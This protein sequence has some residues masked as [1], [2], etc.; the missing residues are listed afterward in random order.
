[1]SARV[2]APALPGLPAEE[3]LR[4]AVRGAWRGRRRA[5]RWVHVRDACAVGSTSAHALCRRFGL[6]PDEEVGG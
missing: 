4:R 6:D 2:N 3:L 1:M 5:P